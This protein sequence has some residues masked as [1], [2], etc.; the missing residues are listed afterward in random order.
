MRYFL[1]DSDPPQQVAAAPE[2]AMSI[3]APAH[4][5]DTT[6]GIE[7]A[8]IGE[9]PGPEAASAGFCQVLLLGKRISNNHLLNPKQINR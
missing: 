7:S 2:L 6:A 8:N 1:R 4:G 9:S 5:A 3:Q